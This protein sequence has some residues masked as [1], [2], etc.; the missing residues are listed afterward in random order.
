MLKGALLPGQQRLSGIY[1]PGAPDGLKLK[2][3]YK[4]KQHPVSTVIGHREYI[5]TVMTCARYMQQW[6]PGFTERMKERK[7]WGKREMFCG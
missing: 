4:S 1:K 2:E 6:L 3:V 5:T 7:Y